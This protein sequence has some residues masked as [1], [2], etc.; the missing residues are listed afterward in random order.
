MVID[1][2]RAF[3][4]G[5]ISSSLSGTV[6]DSSGSFIPGAD[7]TV[8]NVNT[9]D[10]LRAVTSEN[11]TFNIPA[12][13]PGT[14]EVSVSLTGFKRA[15]L[16]NVKVNAATPA[17]VRATL[18]V[19]ELAEVVQVSA[20]AEIVQTQSSALSLTVNVKQIS[21]IPLT[22]RNVL[23]FVPL[24]PGFNTPGGNRDTT[25][26]GL[27]QSAIN[28]TY[29]GV[30]VQDNT[31]KTT[32]GFFATAAAPRRRGRS[33]GHDGRA[34][35]RQLGRRHRA[36]PVRD[37]LG[38]QPVRGSAYHYYRN[39]KFNANTWFNKRDGTADARPSNS[40]SPASAS[41]ARSSFPASGTVTTRGSSS[42]TMKSSASRRT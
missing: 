21:E 24:L 7:V 26:F 25:V 42:S 20:G 22:T 30:N 32:D 16:S 2:A 9:G 28:I 35:R 11:G 6:V 1:H 3:G 33:D 17:T 4:Q 13:N 8:K 27:P 34:G 14:Y 37:T 39:D 23:D 29:D 12:I 15:V 31:L 10:T 41:A 18:D 19:G 5:G 38:H 36:D 40:I